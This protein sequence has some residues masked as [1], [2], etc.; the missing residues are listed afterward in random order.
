LK[1]ATKSVIKKSTIVGAG[2]VELV[3]D[4]AV[5]AEGKPLSPGAA[6]TLV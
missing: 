6:Q 2:V 3:V 1:S 4:H 5:C